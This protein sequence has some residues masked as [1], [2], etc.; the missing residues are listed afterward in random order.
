[1][2]EFTFD[3]TVLYLCEIVVLIKRFALFRRPTKVPGFV[4]VQTRLGFCIYRFAIDLCNKV[5]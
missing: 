2:I 4:I 3:R 1:M 5:R